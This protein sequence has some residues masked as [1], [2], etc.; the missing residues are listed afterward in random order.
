MKISTNYDDDKKLKVPYSGKIVAKDLGL[1]WAT[2]YY[3]LKDSGMSHVLDNMQNQLDN[4]KTPQ[5]SI[6]IIQ[7]FVKFV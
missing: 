5:E 2:A 3:A 7:Q 4:S 1:I 6:K